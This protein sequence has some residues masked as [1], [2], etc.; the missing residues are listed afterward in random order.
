MVNLNLCH[1]RNVYI[2][3]SFIYHYSNPFLHS[4]PFLNP[5]KTSGNRFQD[6]WKWNIE[7]EQVNNV[8]WK[9]I[10]GDSYFEKHWLGDNAITQNSARTMVTEFGQ[11]DWQMTPNKFRL[12]WIELMIQFSNIN[13][14]KTAAKLEHQE[15]SRTPIQLTLMWKIL[16][17]SSL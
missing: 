13:W 16:I 5:F 11:Q 9:I 17:T 8:S 4:V 2:P 6:L 10:N 12:V 7:V 14:L 1:H 3:F 15:D